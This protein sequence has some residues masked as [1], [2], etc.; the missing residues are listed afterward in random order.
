MFERRSHAVILSS[1][2]ATFLLLPLHCRLNLNFKQAKDIAKVF[3]S[4]GTGSID[5]T[6]FVKFCEADGVSEAIRISKNVVEKKSYGNPLQKKLSDD[7][8][9]VDFSFFSK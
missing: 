2:M 8:L 9:E 4:D 1:A 3:D 5:Y 6:E 7:V